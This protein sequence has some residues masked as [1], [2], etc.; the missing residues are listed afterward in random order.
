MKILIQNKITPTRYI[1]VK[2]IMKKM[3]APIIE[4]IMISTDYY[5]ALEGSHRI[6]CAK[7][8]GLEPILN[9][10]TDLNDFE[11]DDYL[12][13]I[14]LDVQSREAKGLIVTF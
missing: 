4:C 3:G 1:K 8:L 6:T 10:I 14:K 9:V 12:Y 11:H 13:R 7:E 5:Y 2:Q